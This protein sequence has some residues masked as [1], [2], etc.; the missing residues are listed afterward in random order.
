MLQGSIEQIERSLPNGF[1]D[2][3]LLGI[4]VNWR[5]ARATFAGTA[6]VSEVGQGAVRGRPFKLVVHGL[7]SLE[8]PQSLKESGSSH[9]D[10]GTRGWCGGFAGWPPEREAKTSQSEGFVYSFF[11]HKLNDFISVEATSASF[12]WSAEAEE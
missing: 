2:A 10:L 8:L 4:Q 11:L 7:R 5:E 9:V 3:S 1:H 12:E 6:D